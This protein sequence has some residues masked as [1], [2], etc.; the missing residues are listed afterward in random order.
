MACQLKMQ[1]PLSRRL[2]RGG[3]GDNT[4]GDQ[5]QGGSVGEGCVH[6]QAIQSSRRLFTSPTKTV[7]PSLMSIMQEF[8]RAVAHSLKMIHPFL[9]ALALL[10]TLVHPSI[11]QSP[12]P[13]GSIT[14]IAHIAFRVTDIDRETSFFASLGFQQAFTNS[15]NG[16]TTQAFIKIND[17]QFI[18]LYAQSAPDQPIGWM[19]VCYKV[20][21]LNAFVSATAARGLKLSAVRKAGAGNLLSVV[22]DPDGRITE[23]TQYMPGSR[24][25]LDK[26]LHLGFHRVSERMI[27]FVLPISGIRDANAFYSPLGFSIKEESDGL[28]L[29]IPSTNLDIE[30]RP[31]NGDSSPRTLFA[32]PDLR[33]A[34]TQ[35]RAEGHMPNREKRKAFIKDP[36]G[37]V[38]V[39]Q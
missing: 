1:H 16:K 24:H 27:G 31:S 2:T 32:V 14:G 11:A 4:L 12:A 10:G 23:F 21:D 20:D 29:S 26:G 25:T 6:P 17:R 34:V 28:R 19:H 18:E 22:N 39:F 35:L 8:A 13:G 5:M 9:F 33:E 37:N 38:F 3:R 7:A 30:L 15:T 36:D